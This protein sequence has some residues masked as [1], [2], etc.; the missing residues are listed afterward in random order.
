MAADAFFVD[1]RLDLG[2]VIDLRCEDERVPC[3]TNPDQQH[4]NEYLIL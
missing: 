4:G 1:D 3:N 2:I